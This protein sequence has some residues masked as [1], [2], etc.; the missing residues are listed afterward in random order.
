MPNPSTSILDNFNRADGALGSNWTGPWDAANPAS[1]AIASNEATSSVD[2]ND[3]VWNTLL[4]QDQE[5]FFTAFVG[6]PSLGIR[7]QGIGTSS[8][9]GYL[10]ELVST[11]GYEITKALNGGYSALASGAIPAWTPGRKFWMT[12]IGNVLT[13]YLD[14]DGNSGYSQIFQ[15]TDSSSPILGQGYI[16]AEVHTSNTID[17]FGGGAISSA[18]QV[19]FTVGSVLI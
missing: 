17:G 15:V 16:G 12:A 5:A 6:S 19:P 8:F 9:S 10:V 4:A 18:Q 1:C 2:F 11:P 13:G 14:V 7:W 3:M